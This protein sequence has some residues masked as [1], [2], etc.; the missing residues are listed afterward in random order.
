MIAR[1]EK[2]GIRVRIDL[3]RFIANAKLAGVQ[4]KEAEAEEYLA[5]WGFR[6][7]GNRLWSCSPHHLDLLHNDE[8]CN[9]RPAAAWEPSCQ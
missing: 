6:Q 1:G 9:V 2:D 8:I 7:L 5:E 3:D 4:L